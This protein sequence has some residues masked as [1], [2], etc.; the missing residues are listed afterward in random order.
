MDRR[1]V[2]I[3]A[4]STFGLLCPLHELGLTA[5]EPMQPGSADRSAT[6]VHILLQKELPGIKQDNAAVSISV[7]R[8][9]YSPGA[10]S[11]P[12]IHS[13]PAFVYV[14][15]GVIE[16]QLEGEQIHSYREG[17]YFFEAVGRK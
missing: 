12:H 9:L 16:S 2:L 17:E 10:K 11:R 3:A 8:V 15:R 13:S 7:L 5:T 6:R 4:L 14:I 1:E